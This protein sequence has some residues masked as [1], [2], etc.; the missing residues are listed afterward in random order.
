MKI[1]LESR[2]SAIIRNLFNT[3]NPGSGVI[4]LPANICPIVPLTLLSEGHFVEFI[5]I[6]NQTLCI[7]EKALLNRIGEKNRLKILGVLYARTFGYYDRN[8]EIFRKIKTIAPDILNIDDCCACRPSFSENRNK[9]TGADVILYSTGYGKYVDLGKGG[10]AYLN[11]DIQ[12]KRK[13][14]VYRKEELY[15]LTTIYRKY[16]ES[17]YPLGVTFNN[18]YIKKDDKHEI[19]NLEN[20]LDSEKPKTT[21]KDYKKAVLERR[22]TIDKIKINNNEIYSCRIPEEYQ[23]NDNYHDWRYQIKVPDKIAVLDKIVKNGYFA[24]GHYQSSA[25]L[26]GDNDCIV[27]E[28]LYR[29]ILNLFNDEKVTV[30]QVHAVASIVREYLE[31]L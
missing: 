13:E 15:R 9:S 23:L 3:Y 18:S 25:R 5:D 27:T 4:I 31:S 1:V 17:D 26:F 21:W 7:D 2:A 20:W 28:E 8:M 14:R 22:A 11:E 24:S 12:Y 29:H 30:Y 6:N 16:L 19:W 10:Y